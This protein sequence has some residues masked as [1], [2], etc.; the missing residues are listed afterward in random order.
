MLAIGAVLFGTNA[1][2]T[3][4]FVLLISQALQL[5]FTFATN[6]D[7]IIVTD[8]FLLTMSGHALLVFG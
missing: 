2:R 6:S 5:L 4:Y 1:I 7:Q 8:T 3:I